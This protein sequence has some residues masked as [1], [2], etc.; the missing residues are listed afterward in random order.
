MTYEEGRSGRK[1]IEYTLEQIRDTILKRIQ[2]MRDGDV[3]DDLRSLAHFIEGV[4]EEADYGRKNSSSYY[5]DDD[6]PCFGLGKG[7]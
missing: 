4:F 6:R 5:G 2:K 1:I 7:D 3:D